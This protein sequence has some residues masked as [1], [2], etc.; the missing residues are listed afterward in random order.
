MTH[1]LPDLQKLDPAVAWAPWAPDEH[2]GRGPPYPPRP[3]R[4][5]ELISAAL[6]DRAREAIAASGFDSDTQTRIAL[7]V[8]TVKSLNA[9]LLAAAELLPATSPAY[10]FMH[11]QYFRESE[12]ATLLLRVTRWSINPQ[13]YWQ[14]TALV[15]PLWSEWWSIQGPFGTLL[16]P[17]AT[18]RGLAFG[19][20][21][22][23]RL[24]LAPV[25]P[26][27]ADPGDPFVIALQRIEQENGRMIQ[28][29]IRLLKEMPVDIALAERER[30]VEAEQQVVD[31]VFAR[32]LGWLGGEGV[33]SS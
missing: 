23:A 6:Y 3:S 27:A 2:G 4:G 11:G 24:R 20:A 14:S 1:T 29:Q 22:L 31:A 5:G 13:I 28:A 17:R 32:F 30:I 33:P 7:F 18:Y 12:F 25:M 16:D 21:L 26:K 19:H 15:N 9:A 8:G 10:P